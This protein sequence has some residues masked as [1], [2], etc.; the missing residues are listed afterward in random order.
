MFVRPWRANRQLPEPLATSGESP[1]PGK[2]RPPTG[3][4][5]RAHV[6][7]LAVLVWLSALGAT[8]PDLAQAQDVEPR[9]YVASPV[10]S[11]FVV[12][13]IGRSTGAVV[14]DPSL[15]VEDVEAHV[16]AATIGAGRTFSLF[17]RTAL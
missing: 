16:N 10:G 7:P 13:G 6:P 8:I 2:V 1:A 14:V 3:C 15:P 17:G 11:N 4:R 9:A 12:V 5:D